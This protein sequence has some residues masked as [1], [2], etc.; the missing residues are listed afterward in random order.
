M[1]R[2]IKVITVF[3]LSIFVVTGCNK[4]ISVTYNVQTG[5]KVEVVLNTKENYK[6]TTYVPFK[7]NRCDDLVTIGQFLT[8]DGYEYYVSTIATDPKVS[9]KR[10]DKKDDHTYVY[11]TYDNRSYEYLV[12]LKDSK[13]AVL[14]VTDTTKEDADKVFDM[15]Q[16]NLK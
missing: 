14:L 8:E 1:K 15:L 2:L 12:Y 7:I 13:T 4:T 10:E 6:L 16:F 9:D 3:V 5:D 11:W